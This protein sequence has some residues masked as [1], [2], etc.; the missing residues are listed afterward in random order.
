MQITFSKVMEQIWN[1]KILRKK[2]YEPCDEGMHSLTR[3][4]LCMLDKGYCMI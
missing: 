4:T 2:A 3:I 1:F